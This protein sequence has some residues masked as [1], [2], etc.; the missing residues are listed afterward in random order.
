MELC[1][2]DFGTICDFIQK[3]AEIEKTILIEK[4][5]QLINT[6]AIHNYHH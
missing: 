3:E 6:P 5:T 4:H 2:Y 1:T